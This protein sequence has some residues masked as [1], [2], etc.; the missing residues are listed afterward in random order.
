MAS[1]CD[2]CT[3][4]GTAKTACAYSRMALKHSGME[5]VK[6]IEKKDIS[7][8]KS[9]EHEIIELCDEILIIVQNLLK[10][11]VIEEELPYLLKD[12]YFFLS[13][14]KK[15]FILRIF[16]KKKFLI[17]DI[18]KDFIIYIKNTFND[19]YK[20][21][22]NFIDIM[23][24]IMIS[25]KEDFLIFDLS[26]E[27]KNLPV[28][29]MRKLMEDLYEK[30][31][32]TLYSLSDI[33]DNMKYIHNNLLFH[34]SSRKMLNIYIN[35]IFGNYKYPQLQLIKTYLDNIILMIQ[36][37][38]NIN[39][40]LKDIKIPTSIKYAKK[41]EN[42]NKIQ[43]E[44]IINDLEIQE[45]K[46][47]ISNL[48]D[49]FKIKKFYMIDIVSEIKMNIEELSKRNCDV[50]KYI[51]NLEQLIKDKIEIETEIETIVDDAEELKETDVECIIHDIV[52]KKEKK[53]KK[54]KETKIILKRG[55]YSISQN[56]RIDTMIYRKFIKLLKEQKIND[57]NFLFV[58]D[59]VNHDGICI[60][61]TNNYHITVLTNEKEQQIIHIVHSENIELRIDLY[62]T[63]IN[64]KYKL[65]ILDDVYIKNQNITTTNIHLD[66]YNPFMEH[67][68]KLL[69]IINKHLFF[70]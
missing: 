20:L 55:A 54:D 7:H 46:Q 43:R 64:Q 23:S 14:F 36:Y 16:N 1:E 17:K 31:V 48:L 63:Y 22:I 26:L 60:E 4:T 47:R 30:S 10:E 24:Q 6:L 66:I 68:I 15:M 52:S 12:L 9:D 21:Y 37:L 57:S 49:I 3:C 70:I 34:D 32:Y 65:E 59:L 40:D 39:S 27:N 28:K 5:K 50:T 45:Y 2:E 11:S 8:I 67:C 42:K 69:K 38:I 13:E 35:G 56:N 33:Q 61:L 25:H 53:K 18:S 19:T 41:L 58:N 62:V 44:K 51:N 29:K